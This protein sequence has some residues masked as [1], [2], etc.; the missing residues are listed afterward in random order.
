[1]SSEEYYIGQILKDRETNL[2]FENLKVTGLNFW[3]KLYSKLQD[4][5]TW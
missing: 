5:L 4:I 1:M 2:S 3:I